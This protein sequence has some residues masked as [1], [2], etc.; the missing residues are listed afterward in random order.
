MPRCLIFSYCR[1]L[2]AI[3]FSF[4]LTTF[5]LSETYVT[6]LH[7]EYPTYQ[8]VRMTNVL[9]GVLQLHIDATYQIIRLL[10]PIRRACFV[11][12][13]ASAL[14]QWMH[15]GNH[16]PLPAAV[17]HFLHHTFH[18]MME[19]GVESIQVPSTREPILTV[20]EMAEFCSLVRHIVGH[21][22]FRDFLASGTADD[23]VAD[24]IDGAE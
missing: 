24:T 11:S 7:R 8:R 6:S 2:Q 15:N 12:I 23:V 9:S 20:R 22:Y 4:D 10:T 19:Y 21:Q 3:V 5:N 16:P 1:M 13:C 17:R 18:Y 14:Y